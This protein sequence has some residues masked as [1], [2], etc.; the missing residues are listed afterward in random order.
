VLKSGCHIE[1]TQ[2]R[3]FDRIERLLALLS[4]VALR[5]LWLTYSA[6]VNGDA[7]CTVAFSDTE[8][9]VLYRYTKGREPPSEPPKLSETVRWLGM[10]GGFLARN[11]DGE[12]GVKVLWRGMIALHFMI[13]GFLLAHPTCG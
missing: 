8:W 6:R 5:L 11:G 9:Q 4:V 1:S 2:L 7:S 10:L 13:A 3:T 12:P